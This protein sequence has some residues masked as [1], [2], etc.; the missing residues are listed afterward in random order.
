MKNKTYIVVICNQE[1][2]D[3]PIVELVEAKTRDKAVQKV[4]DENFDEGSTEESITDSEN[5]SGNM[6]VSAWEF[7][8]KDIIK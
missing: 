1:E 5:E 6:S 4:I 8:Q 7:K 3:N 2:W